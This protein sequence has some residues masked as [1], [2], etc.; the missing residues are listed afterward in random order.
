MRSKNELGRLLWRSIGVAAAASTLGTAGCDSE[1]TNG[2]GGAGAGGAA[3]APAYVTSTIVF[4]AEGENTYVSLL[5]D[6]DMDEIDL[7]RS[8][9][10]PGWSGVWAESG[11]LFVSSG[12]APEMTRYTVESSTEVSR[13]DTISFA[14]EG[15]AYAESEFISSTKAYVFAEDAVI[16]N[17]TTMLIDGT[18]ELPVV[19]DREDMPYGGVYVGRATAQRDHRLYVATHWANWDDYTVSEDSLIVVIDTDENRV[20]DTIP[21]DCPYFDFTSVDED[22]TVYFSNW[23][24]SVP[25]TILQGKRK[26]CAV[27]ILPGTDEIDADWSLTFADVTE[28]REGAALSAI[29]GGKAVFSVFYDE[30]TDKEGAID[31]S[32][33]VD[34][35]YWRFWMLDLE[36]LTAEPVEGIDYFAGGY[37]ASRV[38]GEMFVLLPSADYASTTVY[39]L[40]DDGSATERWTTPGWSTEVLAFE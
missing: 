21:V 39:S 19:E 16:W 29:G 8:I 37:G 18:F 26:A 33:Y 32:T 5:D 40:A 20:I 24:Y 6:L 9:E 25:Q 4:G 17:P 14:N 30:L 38:G 13:D 3:D 36:E 7:E 23:G 28:G 10:F 27:R 22:G 15:A 2:D 31:L 11:K 34:G 12:D 1:D 35:A